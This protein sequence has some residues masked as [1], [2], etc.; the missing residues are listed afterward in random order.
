MSIK[1]VKMDDLIPRDASGEI[2]NETAG[3]LA[4]TFY[5]TGMMT[6]DLAQH[7]GRTHRESVLAA[8]HELWLLKSGLNLTV[9][10]WTKVFRRLFKALL[11]DR[12]AYEIFLGEE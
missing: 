3:D 7:A 1:D 5:V 8:Q 6:Y 4:A 2:S 9:K 11:K 10:S 12:H